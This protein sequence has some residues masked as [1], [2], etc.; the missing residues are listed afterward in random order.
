M[1]WITTTDKTQA[2]LIK[3]EFWGFVTLFAFG[4]IFFIW[5]RFSNNSISDAPFKPGFDKIGMPFHYYKN[6]VIPVFIEFFIFTFGGFGIINFYI[7][8]QLIRKEKVLKNIFLLVLVFLILGL[9]DAITDTYTHAYWYVKGSGY[10]TTQL[11]I[12]SFLSPVRVF[13]L[14]GVYTLLKYTGLYF[15]TNSKTIQKRYSFVQ[16]DSINAFVVWLISM[17]V[18]IIFETAKEIILGWGIIAPVGIL[19]YSYSFYSLIPKSLRKQKAFLRYMLRVMLL[20]V[21][22]LFPVF[23]LAVLSTGDE[24]TASGIAAFNFAFQLLVTAPLSWLLYK[25]YLKGNEEIQVLQTELGRSHANL[26]FLRSQI[27]PHFLFNAMNTLY[28]TAIQENAERTAEGIQKLSD[29]MRFMLQENMQEKISLSREIEYLENYISLQKLRTDTTPGIQIQTDI[30]E[31]ETFLQIAPMLLIPFVENAF[32]HGISFREPSHIKIA[33]EIKDGILYFDVNNS[34]HSRQEENDPEKDKSGIGLE[35][36][37]QR[38]QLL[39]PQKHQLLIRETA[40]EFFVHLVLQ[41]K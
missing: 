16:R 12:K 20:L 2:N 40:K 17:F 32:K 15:I 24:E 11:V 41:L 27:N 25:R 31:T 38:L 5:N 39:Y 7:V 1:K 29:M 14:F 26:D 23:L 21:I 33:L 34:R 35:N 36:V 8:P 10:D 22:F 6:Y 19:L 3:L 9:A 4:V 18:L 30:Q 28:G 13:V 37:K